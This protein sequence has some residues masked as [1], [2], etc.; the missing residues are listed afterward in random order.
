MDAS[1]G[2]TDDEQ[3][4]AQAEQAAPLSVFINYRRSD[5]GEVG[6]L[7]DRLKQ[8]FGAKNVFMDVEDLEPGQIWPNELKARISTC[9]AFLAVIGPKWLDIVHEREHKKVD[10][11][12]DQVEM[13][14]VSALREKRHVFA[15]LMGRATMPAK[16]ALPGSIRAH[17]HRCA[18]Y[19][20]RELR[21]RRSKADRRIGENQHPDA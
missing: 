11:N 14:I 2:Q 13:E 18:A 9:D 10:P 16:T 1:E 8:R 19:R 3:R 5:T 7:Y 17:R 6:R 4:S 20:N 15:V 12:E 21:Q